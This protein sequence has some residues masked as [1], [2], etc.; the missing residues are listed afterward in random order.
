MDLAPCPNCQRT[1]GVPRAVTT[2]PKQPHIFK[3][4]LTCRACGHAWTVDRTDPYL[5][6]RR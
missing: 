4:T 5:A 6:A 1:T 3:V 2:V